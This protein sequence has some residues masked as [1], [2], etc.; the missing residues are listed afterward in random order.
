MVELGRGLANHDPDF[1]AYRWR[2]RSSGKRA[3]VAAV[4]V[5]HRAQSSALGQVG[6]L[7]LHTEAR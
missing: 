6:D 4:A 3:M 2:L 1:A 7:L 5:G